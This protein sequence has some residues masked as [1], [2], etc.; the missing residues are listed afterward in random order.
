MHLTFTVD[1]FQL[2]V[3][4]HS[5]IY[6]SCL[7]SHHFILVS[8]SYPFSAWIIGYS[9]QGLK[10]AMIPSPRWIKTWRFLTNGVPFVFLITGF[11]V[12]RMSDQ[13]HWNFSYWNNHALNRLV[14]WGLLQEIYKR[15]NQVE[16]PSK[17]H[18]IVKPVVIIYS[19][20]LSAYQNMHCK[21]LTGFQD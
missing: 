19:S 4:Q 11:I 2:V 13:K 9:T 10:N 16:R 14:I 7:S 3:F 5:H 21:G 8:N 1:E 15:F 18:A 12:L 20:H 17:M 6:I